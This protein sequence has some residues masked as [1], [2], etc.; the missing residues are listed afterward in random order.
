MGANQN[1]FF[2]LACCQAAC[3]PL[4]GLHWSHLEA[5][6][7]LFLHVLVM[8]IRGSDSMTISFF[9]TACY[10]DDP[11]WILLSTLGL[12][13]FA[14]GLTSCSVQVQCW[15]QHQQAQLQHIAVGS[16]SCIVQAQSALH[17]DIGDFS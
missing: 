5:H 15:D 1:N 7:F 16:R 10:S 2:V 17:H 4:A 14:F 11:S 6:T 12:F 3:G 9:S 13:S 8:Y